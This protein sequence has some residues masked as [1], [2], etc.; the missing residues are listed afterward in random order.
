MS[1]H[2]SFNRSGFSKSVNSPAGRIFRLAAG[3]A[4]LLVGYQFR[5]RPLGILSMVW[6]IF[7]LSAGA[8]DICYISA[9]LGGPLSGKKIRGSSGK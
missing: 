3:T 5:D 1:L 6:S 8:F 4:F 2:E 9:A 7:P